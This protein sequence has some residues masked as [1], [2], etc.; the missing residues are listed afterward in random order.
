MLCADGFGCGD[1]QRPD[2]SDH[3]RAGFDGAASGGEGHPDGFDY[4]VTVLRG[5]GIHVGQ[6]GLGGRARVDLIG[7]AAH[8][9]QLAGWSEHFHDRHA[10][11]AKVTC[12]AGAV[13]VGALDPGAQQRSV[14]GDEMCQRLVAG[15]GCR[16][17]GGVQLLAGSGDH[18]RIVRVLVR[19]DARVIQVP[20]AMVCCPFGRV[21]EWE[22]PA[23]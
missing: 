16:E 6:R 12:Q 5:D 18:R 14:A 21:P 4:S 3:F 2:L 20:T 1:Q 8:S 10:D 9:P 17:L 15:L 13:G 23:G 19:V 11:L 7:L 22:A